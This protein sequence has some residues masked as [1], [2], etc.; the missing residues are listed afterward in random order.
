LIVKPITVEDGAWIGARATVLP[1]VTVGSH[2][3][4]AA[5]STASKNTNPNMI[6]VGNP[7]Q[8]VKERKIR[9]A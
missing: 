4:L 5:G 7:A 3:V 6:Y 1:G 9:K 2:S 8:P